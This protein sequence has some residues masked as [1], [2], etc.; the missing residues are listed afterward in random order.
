MPCS[1]GNSKDP[2][3]YSSSSSGNG[4]QKLAPL[5]GAHPSIHSTRNSFPQQSRTCFF[6]IRLPSDLRWTNPRGSRMRHLCAQMGRGRSSCLGQCPSDASIIGRFWRPALASE[7]ISKDEIPEHHLRRWC[8]RCLQSSG[9]LERSNKAGCE[10]C[11]AR[12]MSIWCYYY[13][14]K[15]N[16][17]S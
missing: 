17:I 1:S 7:G 9:I 10:K 11:G 8:R 15:W 13:R 14:Q 12:R 6:W 5:G 3:F 16:C 4:P 2:W